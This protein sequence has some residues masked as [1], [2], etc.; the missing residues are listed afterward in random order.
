MWVGHSLNLKH[1]VGMGS[2][3]PSCED[4]QR[5]EDWRLKINWVAGFTC[6][7]ATEMG[8]LHVSHLKVLMS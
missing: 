2:L 7:M 4:G 6:K 8:A 1:H 3:G 5:K